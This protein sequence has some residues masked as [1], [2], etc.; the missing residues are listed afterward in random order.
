MKNGIQSD[1]IF[2]CIALLF[3]SS[4]DYN[5]YIQYSVDMLGIIPTKPQISVEKSDTGVVT[6]VCI[7]GDTE[8]ILQRQRMV[9]MSVSPLLLYAGY[10]MDAPMYLRVTVATMGVVCFISHFTA[11]TTVKPY[12]ERE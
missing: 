6:K 12:L 7:D 9:A 3:F 8:K 10:K 2:F 4:I 1:A 11:Y 5:Q